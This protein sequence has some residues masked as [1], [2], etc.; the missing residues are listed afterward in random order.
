VQVWDAETGKVTPMNATRANGG[1]GVKLA[2]EPYA[3]ELVV[4]R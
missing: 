2:L 4:V 1:V 3:T